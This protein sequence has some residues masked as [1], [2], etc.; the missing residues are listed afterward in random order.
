MPSQSVD[1]RYL[2][3]SKN[4]VQ[5]L[6]DKVNIPDAAPTQDSDNLVTSGGVYSAI[7]AAAGSGDDGE[8]YES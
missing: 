8:Y 5:E 3:Y 4:E 1:P 2:S 7:L 6:L